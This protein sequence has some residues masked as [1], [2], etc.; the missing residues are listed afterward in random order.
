LDRRLFGL[1]D[2]AIRRNW[3][4]PCEHNSSGGILN[5]Q[6]NVKRPGYSVGGIKVDMSRLPALPPNRE[7]RSIRLNSWIEDRLSAS[8][9]N[10]G[11]T[12]S[13]VYVSSSGHFQATDMNVVSGECGD[14]DGMLF[15]LIEITGAFEVSAFR[16]EMEN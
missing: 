14:A 9:I 3:N 8:M 15:G 13:T 12:I 2:P 4:F 11:R 5:P 6:D 16:G 1:K 10:F 7:S